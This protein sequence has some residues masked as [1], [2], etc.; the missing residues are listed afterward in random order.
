MA[1]IKKEKFV[2]LLPRKLFGSVK[3]KGITQCKRKR[4]TREEKNSEKYDEIVRI[5]FVV[6][7]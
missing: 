3:R 4:K 1:K 2:R 5:K 7:S 6:T